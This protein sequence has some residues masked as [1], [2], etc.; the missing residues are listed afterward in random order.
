MKQIDALAVPFYEFRCDEKL[1]DEILPLIKNL[2]YKKN[3]D[4]AELSTQYFYHK[5]LFKW[6]DE[7]LEE[8]RQLYFDSTLKMVIT[9][10]WSTKTMPFKRHITHNH[11]QT[12]I[13]GILYL[14]DFQSGETVF[15]TPNPWLRY[16]NEH[17]MNVSTQQ[18]SQSKLTTK[19]VPE[20]GKLVLYPPHIFHGTMPNKDKKIR[21]TLAFDAFFSGKIY[22]NS[23]W[24][25]VE[26]NSSSLQEIV[27]NKDS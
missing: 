10:C 22:E 12:L 24:P 11:Q 6:F 2:D 7:C 17:I 20:K 3:T 19:I 15:T 9:T 14:D 8:V 18:L 1:I 13:G 23:N 26:I 25:Y 27:E 21:H 4:S 16:Q 5:E